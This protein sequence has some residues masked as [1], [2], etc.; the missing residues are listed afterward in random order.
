MFGN[1]N[2]NDKKWGLRLL[3][4][5][6]EVGSSKRIF[7]REYVENGVPFFRTKEVV[8][9][10]KGK[11]ITT[12]LYI[13]KERFCEIKRDCGCPQ[14]GDL[15]ISAVGTIGVI[16]VVD[17]R[18][19]YFKDGN[20]LQV[21]TKD[22]SLFL[23]YVLEWLIEDY[24][25]GMSKGTAYAALTINSLKKMQII[26]VPLTM[27]NEFACFVEQTDKSKFRIKQSLEK[28]EKCYKALLQ[29]YF[30]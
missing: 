29:K 14:K 11:S 27:Q 25:K 22:N 20:L 5:F 15:L 17:D 4:S 18:E 23:K 16:W 3:G 28:L 30:G 10:S 19:F 13:S 9:L 12:E 26:E 24:K 1:P 8:E 2:R 6:S 7:E 21:R